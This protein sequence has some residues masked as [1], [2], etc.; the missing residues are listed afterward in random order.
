[1]KTVF[2]LVG[3]F[4]LNLNAAPIKVCDTVLTMPGETP[5]PMLVEVFK[6]NNSYEAKVTQTF[7]GGVSVQTEV[8]TLSAHSIQPNLNSS[9]IEEEN[10]NLAEGLIVHAMFLS[11]D[12]T[13]GGAF[14][15]GF[16]LKKAA[17]AKV[18]QIGESG[19]MGAVAILEAFDSQKKP[20]GSFLGGF[21]LSPCK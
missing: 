17:S 18:Y 10:L 11:E 20:L 21:L 3:L 2:L 6:V 14:T 19:N 5:V 13:F 7:D 8:V 1:M 9:M 12:P 4:A 16:D 15:A